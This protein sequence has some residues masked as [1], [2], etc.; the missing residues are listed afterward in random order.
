MANRNDQGRYITTGEKIRNFTGWAFIIAVFLELV[1]LPFYRNLNQVKEEQTEAPIQIQH[2][3]T[4]KPPPTPPPPTPTPPPTPQPHQVQQHP[5]S[6]P[7][8]L[9]VHVPP[10]HSA[11]A[12][13]AQPV[14]VPPKNGSPNGVPGGTGTA[15]PA[16]VETPGNCPDPNQEAHTIDVPP[17]DYPQAA[18][19]AGLG[20]VDVVVVVTVG[21]SGELVG[22]PSIMSDPAHNGAIEREALRVARESTYAPHLVNCKPVT[23][24]YQFIVTFTPE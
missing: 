2:L 5:Q 20:E 4:L 12:G 14:Y 9:V 24:P 11:G 8:P 15:A 18:E 1:A 13:A 10:V 19:D 6:H 21:P 23:T 17:V 16:P 3:Q 7:R 22:P